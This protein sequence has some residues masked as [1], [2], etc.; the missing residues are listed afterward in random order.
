M[1]NTNQLE[2]LPSRNCRLRPSPDPSSLGLPG[3]AYLSS[4]SPGPAAR[5]DGASSPTVRGSSRVSTR[6][7]TPPPPPLL[8]VVQATPAQQRFSSSPLKRQDALGNSLSDQHIHP[9]D[10]V[11]DFPTRESKSLGSPTRELKTHGINISECQGSAE[12]RAESPLRSMSC[13][14]QRQYSPL[15]RLEGV[16]WGVPKPPPRPSPR[17]SPQP[18]LASSPPGSPSFPKSLLATLAI[19]KKVVGR[20]GQAPSSQIIPPDPPPTQPTNI[21]TQRQSRPRQR[22][23]SLASQSPSPKVTEW[24]QKVER[25]RRQSQTS[26]LA[27]PLSSPF[28]SPLTSPLTSPKQSHSAP[29]QSQTGGLGSPL[30]EQL[31]LAMS[32]TSS[33]RM[34]KDKQPRARLSRAKRPTSSSRE[35][36]VFIGCDGVVLARWECFGYFFKP[37]N[38]FIG[39]VL[40]IVA[41][42]IH[43]H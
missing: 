16:D 8:T 27:S 18:H 35:S 11:K 14:K 22:P 28:A 43:F 19:A 29:R 38:I 33:P 9:L 12:C 30:P 36:F 13:L 4:S 10:R 37:L 21:D 25:V 7:P 31:E 6:P 34:R 41:T 26:P 3:P 39:V 23:D 2:L 1:S 17:K 42:E 32:T 40:D 24:R 5:F 15:P 20:G